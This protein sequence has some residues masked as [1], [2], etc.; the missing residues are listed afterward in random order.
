MGQYTNVRPV[1]TPL[2]ATLDLIL[3]K[4]ERVYKESE[5]G[6]EMYGSTFIKISHLKHETFFG[7]SA[8]PVVEPE[9]D[10]YFSKDEAVAL[11]D[12]LN[13][14]YP[15]SVYPIEKFTVL[16]TSTTLTCPICGRQWDVANSNSRSMATCPVCG[17]MVELASRE[18]T[19]NV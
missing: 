7:E 19:K 6:P 2:N 17:Y 4:H 13:V 9:Q 1:I 3:I 5:V 12:L 8:I 11:R 14:Y 18:V 10:L 16:P 15:S